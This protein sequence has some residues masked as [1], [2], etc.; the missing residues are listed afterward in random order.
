MIVKK[1]I[2][3]LVQH[4]YNVKPSA[5]HVLA[6]RIIVL[7]VTSILKKMCLLL[8]DVTP[9]FISRKN[10][11]V[12]ER[13]DFKVVAILFNFMSETKTGKMLVTKNLKES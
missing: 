8:V 4:A 11:R 6:Q 5:K 12:K 13:L 7:H 10:S 9:V 3:I 2:L 1:A